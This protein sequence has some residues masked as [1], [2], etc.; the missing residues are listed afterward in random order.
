MSKETI[1]P[2]SLSDM[3]EV[4]IAIVVLVLGPTNVIVKWNTRMPDK[5]HSAVIVNY[6]VS[7]KI[8][9]NCTWLLMISYTMLRNQVGFCV[10]NI[11]KLRSPIQTQ[12]KLRS[13]LP[14]R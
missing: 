2:S 8:V 14:T 4:H 7:F 11:W 9:E 5:C 3:I 10:Q 13:M 12:A 1:Y 6:P